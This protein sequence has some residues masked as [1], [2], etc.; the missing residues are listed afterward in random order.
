M[1]KFTIKASMLVFAGMFALVANAQQ[2]QAG[3]KKFGKPFITASNYCGTTEYE[4]HLKDNN[5]ARAEKEAFEQWIAP[6]VAEARLKRLQKSGQG[7]NDVVTIPIVF[8]VL[9]NGDA[10]GEG[11]NLTEERLLSQIQV[12]NEDYRRAADT[13]GFNG[14][15]VGAD[16]EIEFCLA[17][18]TPNGLPTSGIVRYNI[19]DDN[20]WLMEEV[21]AIK[22]QTQWDPAK[23]LNIWIVDDIFTAGGYLAGYAQF[24][25]QSGLDGL[26]GQTSTPGTDGVAL[27]ARFVGSKDYVD[28]G[29]YDEARNMGRSASHEVGH[30]FGLR[31]IW[32][33]GTDCTATDYCADTPPMLGPVYGCELGLDTCTGDDQ[34]DMIENYMA[35]TDDLCLNTFTINQKDRMQAVLANSPRRKTLVTAGSCSLGTASL[36][37]DGAIY[38][39][40][41]D[42]TCSN[43]FSP[44]V[45]F[46]N[47]GSNTITTA[48][49]VYNVDDAAPV[50]YT[51]TGSL[52]AG[53]NTRIELPEMGAT[54]GDHDFNVAIQTVNGVADALASNN[55]R[56]NSFT[57]EAVPE[58]EIFDT[59]TVTIT[60]QTDSAASEVTWLLLDSSQNTIAYGTGYED[61]PGGVLDIQQ[62]AVDNN[63]CYGFVIIENGQ[64]GMPGGYYSIKTADGTVIHEQDGDDIVYADFAPFA[65]NVV[66]GTKTPQKAL[67]SVVLYPNPANSILNIAMTSGMD[68]PDDYTI[69]N[70]LGQ[71]MDNGKITSSLQ[72]LDIAK[73]ASG[74]YFVKLAKGSEAKT[75]QFIKY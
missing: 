46:S 64:D 41:F 24:P 5:P 65:I 53:E 67:N 50:T 32:G 57:F 52:A 17:K 49:I 1:K 48:T 27:G 25:T 70:N 7:T 10:I 61:T 44:V 58:E 43:A 39:L 59:E 38:L 4:K 8:H 28:Q 74:V 66:L 47:T 30:F 35:Y 2:K 63:T 9:H 37:N 21:E 54:E 14:N 56:A 62:I 73:Y 20:G 72:T 69:Y 23:Y 34:P 16:M 31:H 12:L 19:G 26:T 13:P 68:T 40:P 45:S 75:I 11:E 6:K 15:A 33:D 18:R 42:T 36:D 55:T 71:V 3:S 60:V 51:W 22:P 29:P